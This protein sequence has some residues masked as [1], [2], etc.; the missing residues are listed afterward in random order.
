[1]EHR[2]AGT[3]ERVGRPVS[4]QILD[5]ALMAVVD[6]MRAPTRPKSSRKAALRDFAA[7][8]AKRRNAYIDRGRAFHEADYRYLRFLIPEGLKVLEAGC[9]TGR[10]LAA[11]KP[12]D[13]IGVD[14]SP[15]M[16]AI[17]QAEHPDLEFVE[18]DIEDP[19][20]VRAL[21]EPFDVVVMSDTIGLLDDCQATLDSLRQVCH[22]ETR[23]II[24]YYN[25]LWEPI[26][27]LAEWAG[28]RM[29]SSLNN[30]LKP[31]D[32][33]N[34]LTLADFEVV[35]QDWRQLIPLRLFGIG[36]LIN[37][38]VATLPGVRRLCLRNY[39]VARPLRMRDRRAALGH[40][41]HS[42]PE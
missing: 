4:H 16:L 18:G 34:L 19:A 25:Y 42:L 38:F 8:W 17:A 41:C 9:G 10:L 1:V 6:T 24:V 37:R 28:L 30:W 11:L 2:V 13:G 26:L 21:P 23:L 5:F 36:S 35:R 15:E 3:F 33:A 20:V 29:P 22:A 14:M 40:D 39:L 32:I 12:K 27:R 31:A 7:R